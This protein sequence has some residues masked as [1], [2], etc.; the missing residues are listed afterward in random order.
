MF[1]DDAKAGLNK[2]QSICPPIS[3]VRKLHNVNQTDRYRFGFNLGLAY[4]NHNMRKNIV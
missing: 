1:E 2:V 4:R 3:S